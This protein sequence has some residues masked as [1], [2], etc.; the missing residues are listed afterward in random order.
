[1]ALSLSDIWGGSKGSSRRCQGVRWDPRGPP[2]LAAPERDHDQD[3]D[4]EWDHDHVPGLAPRRLRVEEEAA[5]GDLRGV[6]RVF[7]HAAHTAWTTA[8]GAYLEIIPS[9]KH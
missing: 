2:G 9:S 3:D 4:E 5:R 1:M 6:E 8:K 7:L